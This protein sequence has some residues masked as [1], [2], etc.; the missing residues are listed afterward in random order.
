M[1]VYVVAHEVPY[2]GFMEPE[3]VFASMD[4]AKNYVDGLPFDRYKFPYV[5]EMDTEGGEV[6]SHEMW[7]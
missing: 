2:E 3:R 4:E 1:K 5:F 6:I 7:K